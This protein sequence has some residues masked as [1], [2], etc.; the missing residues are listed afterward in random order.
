MFVP[1][2][3]RG[4][5][6]LWIAKV[7]QR[8]SARALLEPPV[9]VNG[10]SFNQVFSPKFSADSA[11]VYFLIPYAA[12]SQAIVRVRIA[13]PEPEFIAA[14]ENFDVVRAGRY[15]GCLVAKI[16]KAKL[17]PGYYEWYW[18]LTPEGKEIAVVGQ[19][20]RDVALFME[21]EQIR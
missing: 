10:R 18:L 11:A 16:R 12:T 14:A 19:D 9:Q 4:R 21:Q 3:D 15:R 20:E 13:T 6:E 1:K 5:T 7:N 17:A 8:G 2:K